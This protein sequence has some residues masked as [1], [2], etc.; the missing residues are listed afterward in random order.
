MDSE[1]SISIN[2]RHYW[3][4]YTLR[5]KI[6]IFLFSSEILFTLIAYYLTLNSFTNFR[7]FIM[8]EG[9]KITEQGAHWHLRILSDCQYWVQRSLHTL[10]GNTMNMLTRFND[11]FLSVW[12]KV[13]I[14][15]AP[16]LVDTTPE[17]QQSVE[18][19]AP[20]MFRYGDRCVLYNL[21]FAQVWNDWDTKK[22]KTHYLR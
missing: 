22:T 19:M 14:L 4:R 8:E 21:S 16:E 5:L 9:W 2:Y 18:D 1:I 13:I 12:S 20:K 15:S 7:L 3:F 17:R 10:K 11:M 6:S